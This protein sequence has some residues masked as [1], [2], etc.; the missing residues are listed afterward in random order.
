MSFNF[1]T[2]IARVT[3]YRPELDH[4]LNSPTGDVGKYIRKRG[5]RILIAAKQQVGVDTGALQQSITLVHD[6]VGLFQQVKIGSN[7]EIALI[8]HE[9]SRPHIIRPNEQQFLRFRKGTR[10]VY[11][12]EVMHPGTQPNRYLSDNLR[13]AFV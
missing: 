8:H 9:G 4:F 11:T 13:L 5:A 12:R 3:F 6:R 1:D 2:Q 7:N 10:M